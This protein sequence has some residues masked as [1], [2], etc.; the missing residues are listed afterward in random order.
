MVRIKQALEMGNLV[1][2]LNHEQ[3]NS[4]PGAASAK[5]TNQFLMCR[6]LCKFSILFIAANIEPP[7]LCS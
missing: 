3:M 6:A 5:G 7:R 1:R 4:G 2:K